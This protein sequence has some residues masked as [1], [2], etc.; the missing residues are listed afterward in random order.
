M[1]RAARIDGNQ[2][3]IVAA[4]RAAGATVQSL[5]AVGHGCPDLL[6]GIN[7]AS[8]LM[9]VKD[10][11]LTP[12]RRRLTPDEAAWHASWKG[13]VVVVEGVDDALAC[14]KNEAPPG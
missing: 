9:E 10:G 14:I 7:G 8:L 1:R 3:E 13:H 6:V 4:L 12:S 2:N 11:S 5:A